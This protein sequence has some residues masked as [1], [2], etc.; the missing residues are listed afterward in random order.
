MS[1][2]PKEQLAGIQSWFTLLD[3]DVGVKKKKF[4][5]S[6]HRQIQRQPMAAAVLRVGITG[7]KQSWLLT[8]SPRHFRSDVAL[9][10]CCIQET[11]SEATSYSEN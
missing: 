4:P 3:L 8:H 9:C 2:L 5:L 11:Q 7:A 6:K 10:A 1:A